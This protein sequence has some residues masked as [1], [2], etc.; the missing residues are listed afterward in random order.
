[1]NQLQNGGFLNLPY[2]KAFKLVIK[3]WKT[4]KPLLFNNIDY[5]YQGINFKI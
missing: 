2:I 3:M 1:M 4:G 5:L